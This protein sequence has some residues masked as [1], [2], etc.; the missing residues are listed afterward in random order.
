[1]K[2][3]LFVHPVSY[4]GG[5]S[6][7]MLALLKAIDR[8]TF[9]PVA[10]LRKEGPLADE[11]RTLGIEVCFF[12]TPAIPYNKS[13]FGYGVLKSYLMTEKA[14]KSFAVLLAK[15]KIDIV[16]LNNMMLYPY[17]KTAKEKGCHTVL[18]VREHWPD[19][20][21]QIQ[22]KRARKYASLYADS[23]V[24]INHYSA[25]MFP[26]CEKRTTI[27]YDW[28][29]FTDRYEACPFE[30]LFGENAKK[31]KVMLFTGGMARI[32]GTLEVVRVFRNYVKG[33][34]YRLL[35][36]GAGLDYK[37]NLKGITGIIERFLMLFGW[38]PYGLKTI[39]EIKKD[40]RVVCIPPTYKIVDIFKQSY[41]MLS[42]FTIPHA[43]LALA[44]AIALGTICV[45][46]Y[47][48][49]AMEYSDLGRGAVLYKFNCK[50]D[51][52]NKINYV[53]T[54]YDEVKRNVFNHSE[55]VA[56]QFSREDNAQRF[57]SVLY[58]LINK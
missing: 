55:S 22:M 11:I 5:A 14:Q 46:A 19:G 43:N 8:T 17:L 45:A 2:R 50:E 57:N 54:H 7:C 42:Y 10:L 37:L 30:S 13:L 12:E 49:E 1:M 38:T 48:D 58:H 31:L 36:M 32:K 29:D 15:M 33:N 40:K 41:C 25:S 35:L 52:Q 39:E 18:H 28:F 16:Y 27:V 9:E 21:H 51:F 20:E 3:V 34:D 23:L 26:E 4:V 56:R 24:A 47:T 44:E 53:I 6:Y